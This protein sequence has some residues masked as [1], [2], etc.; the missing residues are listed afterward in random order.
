L[1]IVGEKEHR[2]KSSV[3]GWSVHFGKKQKAAS[4]RLMFKG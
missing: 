4:S 1:A 3:S 2:R